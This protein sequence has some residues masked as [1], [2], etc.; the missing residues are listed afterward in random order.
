MGRERKGKLPGKRKGK[1]QRE[2]LQGGKKK[3]G[4]GKELKKI[5]RDS[6]V[7]LGVGSLH[8]PS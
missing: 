4:D 8:L 2:K 6:S 3:R 1:E 5:F 7:E